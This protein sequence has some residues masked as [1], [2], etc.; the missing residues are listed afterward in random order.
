MTPLGPG[1]PIRL[2]PYRV[3]GVLGE[4]G[5]GKVYVGQDAAGTLAAVKVLR[6]ELAHDA[7]LAQRFV[8]EAQAAQAVRSPGVAAV[9]GAWTEGGRPWMATEFLAGLT[10][11]EAVDR[12]GPL[13]EGALRALAASLARTVADIHAA[14]FVHR[15]LKPQNIVLTADGPRVIDFG[16]ARPEHG[17]TLTTTGQV[18]VTPGY[19]AP[20]QVLGQRVAPPADVFSLGAVFAYAAT[21]RRAFDGGH[22][23]AVQYAVVHD[24]PE[25]AGLSSELM[26]LVAPCLAKDPALRPTP[27]QI[28]EA[29]APA[30]GAERHWRRGAL[31]EA[32]KER[33]RDAGRLTPQ[34]GVTADGRA[35][36]PDRRRLLTGLAAGGAALAAAG[37]TG[38]WWLAGRGTQDEA[39]PPARNGPFDIPPAARTPEQPL[40]NPADKT[41]IGTAIPSATVLWRVLSEADIYAPSLLPVRDVLVF[42]AASGGISAYDVLDGSRRWQAPGIRAQAEYLSLSDR[43]VAAADEEGVLR[44]YVASTG[45]AKWTC[46]EAEVQ[47]L[48]A[49][50][51]DAVYFLTKDK[52]LRSVGR[53]DAKVRWT[54][55]APASF[56]GKA[57]VSAVA[58][59]GRLVIGDDEGGVLA[60]DTRSGKVAW[61]HPGNSDVHVH[62]AVDDDTVFLNGP[63]LYARRLRDGREI[64]RAGIQDPEREGENWGPPTVRS[65]AV[66]A[67]GGYYPRRL[68]ARDGREVW[69]G[70]TATD[71]GWPL[72]VQGNSAWCLRTETRHTGDEMLTINGLTAGEG[73]RALVYRIPAANQQSIAAEGNRVF[74]RSG[75]EVVALAAF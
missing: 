62:P 26:A 19:G 16:I 31:A 63:R 53:S 58:A 14:G 22:V 36:S 21:G 45:V 35:P 30:K 32:I 12:F 65:G 18:P 13:D 52:K 55:S 48:L 33:E 73:E 44:T 20:E 25:L 54:A 39:R 50:D 74:A 24:E 51:E 64:W 4:G 34:T 37:G 66:Y 27:A 40:D 29:M 72:L 67:N 15:D 69:Q 11:D 17:L 6:P 71:R 8:R 56:K 38:V 43:L 46:R 9:L 49:A 7:G 68:D 60:F 23:A 75:S 70:D 47:Y 41:S 57:A 28:Q 1:D 59:R 61:S 3:F 2:G 42:G 5:M 10:L